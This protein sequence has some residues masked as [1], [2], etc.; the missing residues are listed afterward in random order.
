MSSAETA[1]LASW[2]GEAQNCTWAKLSLISDFLQDVAGSYS[3]SCWRSLHSSNF[4]FSVMAGL[5][6]AIR[7]TA[8]SGDQMID[9]AA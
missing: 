7:E 9:D 2:R 6:P 8:E 4:R 5:D 1:T 3:V